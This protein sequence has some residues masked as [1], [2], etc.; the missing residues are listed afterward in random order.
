MRILTTQQTQL[1]EAR[2]HPLAMA[3]NVPPKPFK[4]TGLRKTFS[5]KNRMSMRGSW[6]IKFIF[7][8]GHAVDRE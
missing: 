4:R 6:S 7:A 1:T 8:G 5:L 2:P 3:A